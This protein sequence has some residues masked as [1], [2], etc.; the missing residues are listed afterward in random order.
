MEVVMS[1]PASLSA[2][3]VTGSYVNSD[4]T[5][6]TG[7][8][9]FRNKYTLTSVSSGVFV[10]LDDIEVELDA[11][12][13]FTV[14]VPASND[15]D[16][17][18]SPAVWNVIE[19]T[20]SRSYSRSYNVLIPYNAP[21]GTVALAS[22]APV[23]TPPSPT[24][25][26]L[27][28]SVG[29]ANGVASLDGTGNVPLSQLNNVSGGATP[30]N[31]VVTETAFGQ[32]SAGGALGSYS[33]GDHTHGT[34]AAPTTGSIG[35]QPADTTLTALAGL[36]GTAGLIVETA[37]DTFTK[38]TLAAGSTAIVITNP[39]GTAG[40]PSF[41]LNTLLKAL[42]ALAGNGL[43]AQTGAGTATNRTITSATDALTVTNGDGVGG[44]PSLTSVWSPP[45]GTFDAVDQGVLVWSFDV[46]SIG[47]ATAN[48]GTGN[49]FLVKVPWRSTR[50]ITGVFVGVGTGGSG[51][52]AG[53]SLV[54]VYNSS[55]TI[56]GTSADQSASWTSSGLKKIPLTGTIS[57][58]GG[59]GTFL[60]IGGL[61]VGTTTP[62][63]W[64][65]PSG[66]PGTA[67][68]SLQS[69]AATSRWGVALAGQTS[70]A[71][72]TP[73]AINAGAS[74]ISIWGALY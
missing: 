28:S 9:I 2:I 21:G 64:R 35:A 69:T 13:A 37:T 4:G 10:Q 49:I 58:A 47:A 73:S 36:D 48:P 62:L 20:T 71:N 63:F 46:A 61:S 1:L 7:V 16:W 15:P 43:V 34:P 12:G 72:F 17:F 74:G 25:Y 54:G 24:L 52:T 27:Q 19:R 6:A 11:T 39:A 51:L 14:A 66:G 29:A 60:W 42:G 30:S 65:A 40:N 22:L 55:G 3:T 26:V 23:V 33:R 5:P 70:L 44:N 68:F 8:V 31:T 18:P 59:A 67:D 38:R 41:D 32:A 57:P 45:I 50:T 53:Q 56:L